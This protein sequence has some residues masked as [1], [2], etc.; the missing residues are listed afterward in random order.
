MLASGQPA[1]TVA[2]G[3]GDSDFKTRPVQPPDPPIDPGLGGSTV[4]C[5]TENPVGPEGLHLWP[6]APA[7]FEANAQFWRRTA[8]QL[9]RRDVRRPHWWD[10]RIADAEAEQCDWRAQQVE[11]AWADVEAWTAVVE[12]RTEGVPLDLA[13][14]LVSG[15][16]GANA[17]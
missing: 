10:V 8:D 7:G 3:G 14:L 1:T 2:V 13:L 4:T 11:R 6:G 16:S 17:D 9:R 5:M 15:G 12:A